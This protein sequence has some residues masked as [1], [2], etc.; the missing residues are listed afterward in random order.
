MAANR[1]QNDP[2]HQSASPAKHWVAAGI[3]LFL[4]SS[5]L[6]Y[7]FAAVTQRPLLLA[8]YVFGVWAGAI[9]MRLALS[10]ARQKQL[11]QTV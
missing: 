8:L 6:V 2:L 1:R 4:I 7:N 5:P 11:S 10:R 3:F 9:G